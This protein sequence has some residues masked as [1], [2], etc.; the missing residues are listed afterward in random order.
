MFHRPLNWHTREL[1]YENKML[2]SSLSIW[3]ALK[4]VQRRKVLSKH[5][6]A[7]ALGSAPDS[8][9]VHIPAAHI[10]KLTIRFIQFR[11]QCLDIV[12]ACY[13]PPL[14]RL[15]TGSVYDFRRQE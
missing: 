15:C 7:L 4:M 2:A 9:I 14:W 5:R 13:N 3:S 12:F 1:G 8:S 11:F 6:D 10:F